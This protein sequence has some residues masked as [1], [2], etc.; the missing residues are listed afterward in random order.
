MGLGL[1]RRVKFRVR[2]PERAWF[3]VRVGTIPTTAALQG[4]GLWVTLTET[5][6]LILTINIAPSHTWP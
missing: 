2:V 6:T 3:R 4:Y 1:R 5:L